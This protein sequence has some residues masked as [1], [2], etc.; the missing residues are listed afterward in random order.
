[1]WMWPL[2]G[3]DP[4]YELP[5]LNLRRRRRRAGRVGLLGWLRWVPR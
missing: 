3:V 4:G 5:A 2:P 1:M